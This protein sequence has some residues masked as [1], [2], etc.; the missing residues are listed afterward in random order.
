MLSN[1]STLIALLIVSVCCANVFADTR[2]KSIPDRIDL[3]MGTSTLKFEHK[4]HIKSVN[5]ICVYC[6]LT[7][8]GK[9]DGGLGND[10][11]RI[12][13]IPCHDKDPGFKADC[14]ECHNRS[15]ANSSK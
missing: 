12:L 15:K 4:K 13:C 3:T 11:A 10:T 2:Q 1:V 14:K 8:N 9:I 5:N 7:E 6:H